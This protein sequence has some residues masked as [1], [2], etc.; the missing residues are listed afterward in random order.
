MIRTVAHTLNPCEPNCHSIVP[1]NSEYEYDIG[2]N[3]TDEELKLEEEGAI[4][5]RKIGMSRP[6][7]VNP[8]A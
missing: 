8:N 2:R 5:S 4:R 3:F 6:L 7:L 1:Q